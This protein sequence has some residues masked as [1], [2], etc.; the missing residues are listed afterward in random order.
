M[1]LTRPR[2]WSTD[3]ETLLLQ[4]LKDGMSAEDIAKDH[5]RSVGALVVR[6]KLI[7]LRM[8]NE[9]RSRETILETTQISFEELD[10]Q[11]AYAQ[12]KKKPKSSVTLEEVLEGTASLVESVRDLEKRVKGLAEANSA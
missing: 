4:Q 2:N 6:R 7:A 10:A 12:K 3:E 8:H 5:S 9:G 1:T 11:I